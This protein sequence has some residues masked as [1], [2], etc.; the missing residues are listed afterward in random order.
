MFRIY[1]YILKLRNVVF[2]HCSSISRLVNPKNMRN[3][4][5][6][7]VVTDILPNIADVSRG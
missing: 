2:I 4:E 5:F 7:R 6:L 3:Q 1:F